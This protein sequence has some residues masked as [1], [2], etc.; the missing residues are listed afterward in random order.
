MQSWVM[1]CFLIGESNIL[2]Q[3]GLYRSLQV[4]YINRTYLGIFGA[5]EYVAVQSPIDDPGPWWPQRS[6]RSLDVAEA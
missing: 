5:P 2:P 1:T 4:K 6:R 3:E